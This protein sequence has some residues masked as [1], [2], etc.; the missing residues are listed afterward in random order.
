MERVAVH[1]SKERR[2]HL[3][4]SHYGSGLKGA[5]AARLNLPENADIRRRLYF[6][7]P[8]EGSDRVF[9]ESGVGAHP[10]TVALRGLYPASADPLG[11]MTKS[12]PGLSAAERTSQR[13]REI[14]A[15][16]Y[17][18]LLLDN[19]GG[20]NDFAVLLGKHDIDM[21]ARKSR[22]TDGFERFVGDADLE[23]GRASCREIV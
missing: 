21:G 16:G 7:V 18:G 2:R 17:S 9:A 13:E 8:R 12:R 22:R 1:F 10:H 19:Y 14:M 15:A 23:I 5:E 3:N 4:T 11:I 6:Y 20:I